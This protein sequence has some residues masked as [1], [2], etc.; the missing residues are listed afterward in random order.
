MSAV[1]FCG[2]YEEVQ[3][4]LLHLMRELANSVG[5]DAHMCA[6]MLGGALVACLSLSQVHIRALMLYSRLQAS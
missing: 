5:Q 6:G 1:H 3:G 2:Q 4:P